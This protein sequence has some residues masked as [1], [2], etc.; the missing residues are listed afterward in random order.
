MLIE[1]I[2]KNRPAEWSLVAKAAARFI[3]GLRYARHTTTALKA[4]SP[5][6]DWPSIVLTLASWA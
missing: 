4:R 6:I 5:L 1:D 3:V 2:L